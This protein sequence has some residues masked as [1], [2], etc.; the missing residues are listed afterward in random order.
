MLPAGQHFEAVQAAADQVDLA[1]EIGDDLVARNSGAKSR[2]SAV[3]LLEL[4]LHACVEPDEAAATVLLGGIHG[5]VR[6]TQKRVDTCTIVVGPCDSDRGADMS[7][8]AGE[9]ERLAEVRD[10]MLGGCIDAL[11]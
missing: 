9:V 5:D 7:V 1:L 10:N 6:T 11:T 3:P 8:D 2:L 4:A